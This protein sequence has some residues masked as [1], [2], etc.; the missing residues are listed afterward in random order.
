MP[1]I[2]DPFA[3]RETMTTPGGPAVIYSLKRLEDQGIANIQRLPYSLRVLLENLLR[4]CDDYLVTRDDV[5]AVAN[6]QPRQD[7]PR[8]IPFLPSRVVLQDFTGVPA[9]VDLAAMRSA[10]AR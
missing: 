7:I 5:L 8:E 9:V 3:T 6:W 1:G 2:K 4:N 10:V